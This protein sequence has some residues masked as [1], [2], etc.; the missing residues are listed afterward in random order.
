MLYIWLIFS[1]SLLNHLMYTS[2]SRRPLVSEVL[3]QR[4]NANLCPRFSDFS[5]DGRNAGIARSAC[6][7]AAGW[8]TEDLRTDCREGQKNLS[9]TAPRPT[10]ATTRSPTHW[11]P[12]EVGFP[13]GSGQDENLTLCQLQMRLKISQADIQPPQCL[14]G[15]VLRDNLAHDNRSVI[16]ARH[17]K[18]A[19]SALNSHHFVGHIIATRLWVY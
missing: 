14:L 2:K 19:S 1:I 6:Y 18:T 7:W 13:E 3:T 9:S 15:V 5:L 8:T 12:G 17:R 10:L 11:V 16:K 4:P